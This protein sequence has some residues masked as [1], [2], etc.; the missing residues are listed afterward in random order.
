MVRRQMIN[1]ILGE[2]IREGQ[3]V[4]QIEEVERIC[5]QV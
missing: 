4:M 1:D 5:D 2:M 3:I